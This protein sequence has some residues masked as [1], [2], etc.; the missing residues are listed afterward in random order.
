VFKRPKPPLQWPH[1]SP[2]FLD[3]WMSSSDRVLHTVL[4]RDARGLRSN[5]SELVEFE[6]KRR[7]PSSV[8]DQMANVVLALLSASGVVIG[9]ALFVS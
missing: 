6:R 7:G 4:H 9:W 1:G 2:G 5:V 8:D 3:P